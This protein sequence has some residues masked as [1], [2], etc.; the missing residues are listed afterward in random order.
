MAQDLK[1]PEDNAE[2]LAHKEAKDHLD[3]ME[4]LVQQDKEVYLVFK[5]LL[6]PEEKSVRQV[7]QDLLGPEET[8][9]VREYKVLQVSVTFTESI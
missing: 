8:E 6:A 7:H 5:D 1:V 2:K 4:G 9:E 3:L